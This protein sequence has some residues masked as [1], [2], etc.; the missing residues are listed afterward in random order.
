MRTY[1][2]LYDEKV[3]RFTAE[4]IP[5]LEKDDVSIIGHFTIK[6]E[7]TT[8]VDTIPLAI[9]PYIDI[10]TVDAYDETEPDEH[11][12]IVSFSTEYSVERAYDVAVDI[13][14]NMTYALY[15]NKDILYQTSETDESGKFEAVAIAHEQ[16]TLLVRRPVQEETVADVAEQLQ[17]NIQFDDLFD[18]KNVEFYSEFLAARDQDAIISIRSLLRS[19]KVGSATPTI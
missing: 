17:F 10:D 12:L 7:T 2:P 18:G 9:R 13:T 6:L 3:I 16:Q 11:N 5:S 8:H 14:R 1:V 15:D 4:R 19:L